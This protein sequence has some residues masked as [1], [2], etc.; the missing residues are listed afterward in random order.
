MTTVIIALLLLQGIP[1]QQGGTV[2]GILRD[3]RGAPVPGVRM[4]AVV[5]P[6]ALADIAE[7]TASIY[8]QTDNEGKYILE[9]VPPGRYVIAAGRLDL[10]TFYPGTQEIENAT[11]VS[12]TPGAKVANINFALVNTSVGRSDNARIGNA[13]AVIPL[14]VTVEGGGKIPITAKGRAVSI[15]FE[16]GGLPISV[17]LDAT[18]VNIP[19]PTTMNFRV[20]VEDLPDDYTIRSIA[21]GATDITNGTFRLSPSNFQTVITVIPPITPPQPSPGAP[22]AEIE[23]RLRAF[24]ITTNRD[25][26]IVNAANPPLA[27]SIT[28][29]R[30]AQNQIDGVRVSGRFADPGKRLVYISGQPGVVFADGSFEFR[31]VKPGRHV[32][33]AT[34][35]P[36]MP[37]AAVIVVGDQDVKDVE[38]KETTLLPSDIRVPHDP[39]PAGN[40]APGAAVPL[41]RVRGRVLEETTK[42][43]IGE[44]EVVIKTGDVFRAIPIQQDGHFES[45]T[46]LPGTYDV[47]FQIFAHS[48]VGPTLTVE[49]KDIELELTSR[50]LY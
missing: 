43:P 34:N 16:S 47:R 32:V 40:Y 18:T 10:Q 37:L 9:G 8:A 35:N 19:G 11:V 42:E 7:G 29:R 27:L 24:L 49:D 38:L 39:L 12:I 21:Y 17:P 48:T 4:A 28:L 25:T 45:F 13:N 30:A 3:S 46:L 31:D 20:T 23:D 50:R 36:T 26:Q 22:P 14:R 15:H 41:A 2:S 1:V 5:R 6:D 44:G 33:A